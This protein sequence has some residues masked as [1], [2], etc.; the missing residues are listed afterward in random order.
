MKDKNVTEKWSSEVEVKGLKP[1]GLLKLHQAMGESLAHSIIE[2]EIE[3]ERLKKRV[4]ELEEALTLK[5]LFEKPLAMMLSKEFLEEMEGS[6]YK[7]TKAKKMLV[8]IMR[9][10][11]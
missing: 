10:V 11:S 8:G 3:N 7:V 1:L 5:P 4:S 6:T 9:Y 2:Y